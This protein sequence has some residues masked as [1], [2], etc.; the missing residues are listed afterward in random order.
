MDQT[1]RDY[2]SF[3]PQ[4]QVPTLV[5]FGADDKATNPAAG[6]WI[7]DVV[8]GARLEIFGRSSHCPFFEEPDAFNESLGAF[9]KEL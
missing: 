2:R 6:K 1:F 5:A 3:L 8:P 9:L 4:I 7:A